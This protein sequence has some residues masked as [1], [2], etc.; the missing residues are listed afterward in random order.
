MALEGRESKPKESAGEQ[1]DE[2]GSLESALARHAGRRSEVG[3]FQIDFH[4]VKNIFVFPL[5]VLQ[6]IYHWNHFYFIFPGDLRKLRSKSGRGGDADLATAQNGISGTAWPHRVLSCGLFGLLF[7]GSLTRTNLLLET[8][9]EYLGILGVS[10]E[11]R[12]IS[13]AFAQLR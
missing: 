8:L 6:G 12:H 9:T 7:T 2:N 4:L 5:L 11:C 13:C 1:A 10:P 3:H